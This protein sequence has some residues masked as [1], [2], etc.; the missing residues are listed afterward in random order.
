MLLSTPTWDL[1]SCCYAPPELTFI[2]PFLKLFRLIFKDSAL[3]L[4][5]FRPDT[6]AWG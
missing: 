6:T 3:A 2:L 4:N 5:Q 1:R